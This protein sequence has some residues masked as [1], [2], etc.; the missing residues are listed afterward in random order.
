MLLGTH[1]KAKKNKRSKTR[2]EQK[3]KKNQMLV[4]KGTQGFPFQHDGIRGVD[5]TCR[6]RCPRSR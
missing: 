4:W 2:P 6:F 3:Q 5:R 1:V